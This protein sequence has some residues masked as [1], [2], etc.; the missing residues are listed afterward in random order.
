[1]RYVA[2]LLFLITTFMV[3]GL[4]L[5]LRWQN[6][7][8]Y[9]FFVTTFLAFFVILVHELGHALAARGYGRRILR[10]AVM[11]F[12]QSFRPLRLR[13]A[14]NDAGTGDVGG[15]VQYAEGRSG[16][17]REQA[18]IAFAGP[19]ANFLLAA[20]AL[21]FAAWLSQRPEMSAL[22]AIGPVEPVQHLKPIPGT[23]FGELLPSS[24][25]VARALAA[26]GYFPGHKPVGA[27]LAEAFAALSIGTGI[28]NLLPFRGSDGDAIVTALFR[29]RSRT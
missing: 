20:A 18:V 16:T 1:M 8:L 15:F 14:H 23:H 27:I 5:E 19:A 17:R 26:P 25:E 4:L 13:L 28:A 12:E 21:L 7:P 6:V 2:T 29:G 22:P 9:K 10:F 11:P 3:Y 24:E